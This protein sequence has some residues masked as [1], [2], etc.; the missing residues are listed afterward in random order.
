MLANYRRILELVIAGRSYS[1]IVELAGCSRRD[2]SRVKKAVDERGVTA[3]TVVSDE[4]L[5]G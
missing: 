1:E 4:D 2:V 3:A 5:A